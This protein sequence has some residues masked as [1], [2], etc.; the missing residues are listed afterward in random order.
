LGRLRWVLAAVGAIALMGIPS[1]VPTAQAASPAWYDGTIEYSTITNCVSIIQG[2]PYLEY[3]AGTYV[4]FN[5]NPDAGL[6][7]VNTTYYLHI[8]V[9]G[10]G[11]SC[12]G[13]RVWPE[14]VLPSNTSLAIDSTNKVYCYAN[15]V[16]DPGECPQSLPISGFHP[17]A[18][19]ILSTDSANGY[20]WPLPQGSNWEFQ[21][22]VRSTTALSN[23]LFG[24]YVDV[25]DGNSSPWLIPSDGVYVFG[26]TPTILYP[27]PATTDIGTTTA[28]SYGNV[29]TAGIAGNAWFELGTTTAYGLVTDGPIPLSTAFT[30][31]QV[32]DDWQ[33]A[34]GPSP[35]QPDTLYHYRL[36]FQVTAGG[37]WYYGADQTFR[38]L[39]GAATLTVSGIGSGSPAG[40]TRNVTV[41]AKDGV[42]GTATDYR[43]TVHFTSTDTKAVLPADYTFTVGDAGVH[44]FTSGVILKTAGTQSVSAR[45]TVHSS[46]TGSQT[47]IVVTPAA[48]TY[49]TVSGIASPYVAGT[50][51]S[52]TVTAKDAY[53]N[54]ATGY[55]G[56][57]LFTS[58]DAHAVLPA[59]YTFTGA[60]AGVHTFSL[61]VTLKTA[62]TQAVRARDTVTATITGLQSGIVV[63]PAAAT[64]LVVS[65][66]SSS[67]TAG[68]AGTITVKAK[69]AFGNTATGYRGTIHFTSSDAQAVLPANYTF[70]AAN[71]GTHT[72]SVTLKTAGSQAV[73]ARDTV[74]ATITGLQ[75]GIVVT[76]AAATTLVVSGL[77]SPRTHGTAGT[78]TVTAHDAYGNTATGYRGTITFTSTDT[79]AVLP[80]NYTFTA[81]NAGVHTFSVNLKTVGTQAVRARD[82]VTTTITGLESGIVVT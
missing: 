16:S 4:G 61:G 77:V 34:S 22:P 12:S 6:P 73:R 68:V 32:W 3:G 65:G 51:H 69:D 15:G 35:L 36:R 8:V 44:T 79:K 74:T 42:G 72:F 48:A 13:Q 63:T 5:A 40:T 43:G 37:A 7:A 54:T 20:T 62:G 50:A 52:V 21:I 11:N 78:I 41:T 49:L 24:A 66:L 17:G 71:A 30:N 9:Y 1:A 53:G 26:G 10:L 55:T 2:D 80:A 76:P 14:I 81:A 75:S 19:E 33:P 64:T 38:T 23:A 82:T 56:T 46:T 58:S 27:S 47:A 70:T 45:D 29:Y 31:W 60:N 67:R 39:G 59:N 57:V 28:K 25:L 18:Y